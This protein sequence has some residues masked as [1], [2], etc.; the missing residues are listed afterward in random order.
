[1]RKKY[2]LF[3]GLLCLGNVYA[4]TKHSRTSAFK[5]YKGLIMAGYQGW[6]NTPED[7]AG[8]GWGHYLQRGEFGPGNIK[9]DLWPET[10]EYVKMYKTPFK[11]ADSS[12]A[13]LP[14]DHDES[15]TD[16][17]FKWMKEYGIDGVFMQRFISNVRIDGI[18]RNH[19][20]KVLADALKASRKYGRAI[21]V[22]Y[23]LSGLRDSI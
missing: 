2:I 8:R 5:S 22:M 3:I 4:Q 6:H 19:F 9:I 10:R 12:V 14:S 20:N 21:S 13:M 1:M 15:T 7:G 17:H 16:L 11:H 23:D 18:V